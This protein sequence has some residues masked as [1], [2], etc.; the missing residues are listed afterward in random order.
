MIAFHRW[1]R[2]GPGDDVVVVLNVGNRA[3]ESYRI[4]TP[5]TGRWRVRLNTDYQGYSA[6][7]GSQPTYDTNTDDL[8]I[9]GMP[10]STSIGLAPYTAVVLSQ[11][12]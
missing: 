10:C 7:F 6:D 5:R 2:G 12:E 4:G 8:P 11:G 1:D 3:Y 9:D